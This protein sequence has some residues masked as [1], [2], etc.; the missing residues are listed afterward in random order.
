MIV[1]SVE[2]T[3]TGTARV[4]AAGQTMQRLAESIGRT[5]T[6]VAEIAHASRA[7]ADDV[8]RLND[9][10]AEMDQS[11]QQNAA[12]VE[13]SMAATESLRGQSRNLVHKLERF[14]IAG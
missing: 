4:H 12:L 13:Q 10:I 1:S 11:T 5:T 2:G 14:T 9:A 8:A 3:E 6:V 7:Q